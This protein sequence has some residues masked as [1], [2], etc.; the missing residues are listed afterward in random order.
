MGSS[1]RKKG[2]NDFKV[3]SEILKKYGFLLTPGVLDYCD[4]IRKKQKLNWSH[5]LAFLLTFENEVNRNMIF[6]QDEYISLTSTFP[7]N[8]SKIQENY[9]NNWKRI[10]FINFYNNIDKWIIKSLG[11]RGKLTR[12]E[13]WE[14]CQSSFFIDDK[15]RTYH[16]NMDAYFKDM[17]NIDSI[18]TKVIMLL[19]S[20]LI[21]F[22]TID[23]L[24]KDFIGYWSKKGLTR[25][26]KDQFIEE[27][28]SLLPP[29]KTKNSEIL[30]N[31]I[32][33]KR[34]DNYEILDEIKIGDNSQK[35]K[36]LTILLKE[37]IKRE[38]Q[39]DSRNYRTAI[40]HAQFEIKDEKNIKF[41]G[42]NNRG[43]KKPLLTLNIADLIL[44]NNV[45]ETR[46]RILEIFHRVFTAWGK[47]SKL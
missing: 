3:A 13:F 19:F 1:M 38:L 9:E 15:L 24:S 16:R 28:L 46:L 30:D 42:K 35:Y 7:V 21:R 39:S 18:N 47:N 12:K 29:H 25:S 4:E 26:E 10:E 6:L 41:W 43:I 27:L 32:L 2:E 17:I 8:E 40:A 37:N 22:E 36:L 23:S 31:S 45:L 44:F 33:L 20:H 11:T 14:L 34:D 5:L